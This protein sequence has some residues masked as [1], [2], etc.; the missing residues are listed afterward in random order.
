[1]AAAAGDVESGRRREG[2]LTALELFE[3]L[4]ELVAPAIYA[5]CERYDLCVF[6]TAIV[7]DVAHYFDIEV[8]PISVKVLLHNAQWLTHVVDGV[9]KGG[10]V[11][12]L[13]DGTWSVG[14]GFGGDPEPGKW[15]GH[16]IAVSD[17][18]FGDFSIK[19]A[20]R[21]Q[22]GIITGPAIVGPMQGGREWMCANEHGT[23]A[24]Y[25]L[26]PNNDGWRRGPDWRRKDRRNRIVGQLIRAIRDT[27]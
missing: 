1:M 16:L 5:R 7:V 15:P 20:E 10:D 18:I 17:D 13:T 9:W 27:R 3:K 25:Q 11:T 23:T 26:D 14:I 8:R 12:K 21:L 19:Q 2:E 4:A 22:Y 24:A 6:A